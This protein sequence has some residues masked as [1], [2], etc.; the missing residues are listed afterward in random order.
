MSRSL[1]DEKRGQNFEILATAPIDARHIT[2][3]KASLTSLT[4]KYNGMICAVNNDTTNNG[5]YICS[6]NQGVDAGDWTAVGSSITIDDTIDD[7][8]NAVKNSAIQTALL[9]KLDLSGGTL[10]G[11]LS[12][13]GFGNGIACGNASLNG[14]NI[15]TT[16]MCEAAGGIEC[17]NGGATLNGDL[18]IQNS[19]T[20]KLK[21][22]NGTARLGINTDSP[23]ETLDV[24]GSIMAQTITGNIFKGKIHAQVKFQT[25]GNQNY[26]GFLFQT[27]PTGT[28]ITNETYKNAM[29]LSRT[30]QLLLGEDLITDTTG[31]GGG[32]LT[33]T[34]GYILQVDGNSILNGNLAIGGTTVAAGVT[35][36]DHQ[37]IRLD[38]SGDLLVNNGARIGKH[39]KTT[40]YAMFGYGGPDGND[41]EGYGLTKAGVVQVGNG[42]LYLQGGSGA[43]IIF[44][45]NA[46]TEFMRMKQSTG[47]FGIGINA[48][49]EKLH[50]EGGNLKAQL[51]KIGNLNYGTEASPINYAGFAYDTNFTTTNYAFLQG[52]GG[53]TFVNAKT[54]KY[55]AFRIQNSDKMRLLSNGNVGIGTITP[56]YTLDVTGNINFT[57][58]LTKDG[59]AYSTGASLPAI[60]GTGGT[61]SSKYLRINSDGT[62]AEWAFTG[63]PSSLLS[64][65][66]SDSGKVLKVDSDGDAR[67][68]NPTKANWNETTTTSAAY[69]QNK[70]TIFS[71]S[72]DDLSDKPSATGLGDCLSS[73]HLQVSSTTQDLFDG[74]EVYNW[75]GYGDGVS[76][77]SQATGST[78]SDFTALKQGFYSISV[79]LRCADGT[80]NNRTRVFG[81]ILVRNSSNTEISR[82]YLSDTYYRD[83]AAN[84]DEAII[85]GSCVKFLNV[86]DQFRV[87]T[88]R[89]D[90]ESNAGSLNV[91]QSTSKLYCQYM[92]IGIA[93]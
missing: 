52:S 83:D 79:F 81:Y 88:Q 46:G 31:S 42:T 91:A 10:T 6:Q 4:G 16:G 44:R 27:L 34:T 47:N 92:G 14:G 7:T 63:V 35:G 82:G 2:P 67:F 60:S 3:T 21:F 66:S 20:T 13:S 48:P 84:Y 72:Y 41:N 62:G 90:K 26:E 43:D 11:G 76:L 38:I 93:Q 75:S 1:G 68:S 59:E 65:S 54:G 58:N 89:T 39:D 69:I 25:R 77:E 86:G 17:S 8:D 40:N 71:G 23:S 32:V 5:L 36:G 45:S 50:I 74:I 80:V 87:V 61:T 51:A 33:P 55:V 78:A 9:A 57:G 15:V 85:C 70:P 30:G 18:Q 64:I 37:P 73:A 53:E 22:N 56:G 12:V 24:N 29:F 19:G 49:T 28:D